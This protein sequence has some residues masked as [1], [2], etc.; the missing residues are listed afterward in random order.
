MGIG[1]LLSRH[2]GLINLLSKYYPEYPWDHTVR[3]ETKLRGQL[4]LFTQVKQL[5]ELDEDGVFFDF[6]YQSLKIE[7]PIQLDIYIPNLLLAFEYH[8][9]S[10]QNCP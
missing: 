2:G 10:I 9:K 8:V 3:S 6:P 7:K 1:N 5:F 4:N